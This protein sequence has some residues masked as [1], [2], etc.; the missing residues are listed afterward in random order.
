MCK[1]GKNWY[2]VSKGKVAWNYT[3]YMNY[4]GK[5]YKVVKGIVEF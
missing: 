5:N 3:G 4:N 1:Y 2:A